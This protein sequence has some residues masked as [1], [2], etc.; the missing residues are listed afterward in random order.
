LA[1]PAS[2]ATS[3]T[4]DKATLEGTVTI[5]GNAVFGET[6]TVNTTALTSTPVVSLGTLTYQW[7]R[8]STN[9]GTNSPTYTLLQADI[10]ST[11]TVT[12]TAANCNGSITSVAT[13]T[14]TKATQTAPAMPTLSS[15]TTTSITLN[16]ITG[17]E[18]R[19]NTGAW[20]T[21][22]L[23]SG[24]T[25]NTS[26][27]FEARKA[28]TA[29][30][31]PSPASTA[32]QITTD[33]PILSGTVTIS[34]NAVFGETLTANTT[35]LTSTPVV[36]L[37]TLTYQWKR[38]S[39]NIGTNS[40]TYTLIQADIGSTITITVTA[41]NCDGS[42]T[43]AA[44]P[45]VTKAT[46]TAP[47]APTR[48]S[49][50]ATSITLN[51][52]TG[53][54]Y[55]RD[56]GAFTSNNVFGG[57]TPDTEYTFTQRKAETDTHLASPASVSATFRTEPGAPPVLGGT[58]TITGNTIF[59]ETLTA[60]TTGLTSTPVGALGTLTCQWK[61]GAIVI[62]TNSASYT[63]VQADIGSTITV[64]V[65]T[66]NCTGEVKSAPTATVTKAE[67]TDPPVAPTMLSNTATGITLNTIEGCE[68]RR[69]NGEWQS[70]TEF[71]G[72]SPD[73]EYDFEARKAETDTHSASPPSA[74]A[75]FKTTTVGIEEWTIDNRQL[76]IYPNPCTSFVMINNAAET[77]IK[78]T[79]ILGKTVKQLNNLSDSQQIP[80][81]NLSTGIYI[82]QLTKD[83]KVKTV[84]VNKN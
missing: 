9:I 29:T 20:Q 56:G 23:F 64:T 30:H 68:Y 34:G 78:I 45:T 73:T 8:G 79:N 36:S 62:G 32:T 39:T 2:T 38:N 31:L 19:M 50:T 1:S 70:S 69:D 17:C 72:L 27:S 42:V 18:Y 7:K 74:K 43:S 53:Y 37:G 46:Q 28:E 13:A 44:T 76:I 22:T 16:A 47:T 71:T 40:A 15:S 81:D 63:L 80:M 51:S 41:A 65:T 10:G 77:K 52:V 57:L 75:T 21:A 84:K 54:E 55:N 49:A 59:G 26:Y 24:L 4:T 25:P 3:I 83:T 58:V 82:F 48:A 11:I 6:L 67:Q 5:S 66:A 61:R 60:N 12:V 33:K 14:V 35:T